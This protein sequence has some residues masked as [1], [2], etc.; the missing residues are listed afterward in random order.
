MIMIYQCRFI[1]HTLV[2]DVNKEKI[3]ACGGQEVH[4]KSLLSSHREPKTALK[5]I[6]VL[7]RK[8]Q[9]DI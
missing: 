3:Y 9:I 7:Q 1:D 6:K 5:K 4:G 8:K 2:G